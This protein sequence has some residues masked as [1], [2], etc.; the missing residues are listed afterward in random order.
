M[1]RM[2]DPD[3]QSRSPAR[4]QIWVVLPL[5]G[6][7]LIAMAL[8]I[9]IAAAMRSVPPRGS[10]WVALAASY[11]STDLI[12]ELVELISSSSNTITEH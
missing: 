12:A 9:A 11:R 1:S 6:L 7:L 4:G 3:P 8:L 10:G 5:L 2:G